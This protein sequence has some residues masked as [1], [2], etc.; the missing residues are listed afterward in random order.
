MDLLE[1]VPGL[2][3][4]PPHGLRFGS[5][6]SLSSALNMWALPA[7]PGVGGG[8]GEQQVAV[9]RASAVQDV[10]GGR[11]VGLAGAALYVTHLMSIF[12]FRK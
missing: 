12:L 9:E 8:A 3:A 1:G 5:S 4:L 7:M 2:P 11:R 6:W 10:Q